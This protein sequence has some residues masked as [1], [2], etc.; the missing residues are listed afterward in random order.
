V[1]SWRDENFLILFQS[2]SHQRRVTW[3][4]RKA[5][6]CA[7]CFARRECHAIR[8]PT[9]SMDR[10]GDGRDRAH[11][12]AGQHRGASPP[13]CIRSPPSGRRRGSL[14]ATAPRPPA[15]TAYRRCPKDTEGGPARPAAAGRRPPF[16]AVRLC[17]SF[18]TTRC[19]SPSP[20]V[21]VRPSCPPR[22]R[23]APAPPRRLGV[24]PASWRLGSPE[25]SS[26]LGCPASSRA[27]DPPAI[28]SRL[29]VMRQLRFQPTDFKCGCE[30][31]VW[32]L[33]HP[34]PPYRQEGPDSPDPSCYLWSGPGRLRPGWLSSNLGRHREG[35]GPGP[36]PAGPSP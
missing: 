32:D 36:N 34:L 11:R 6:D 5:S 31:L 17:P 19:R 28:A 29:P 25:V 35:A 21:W 9:G 22:G 8:A 18:P 12:G 3:G 24:P 7:L 23:R 20:A 4:R 14:R 10:G 33:R 1:R 27:R 13:S 15:P 16:P 2:S 30:L 26:A